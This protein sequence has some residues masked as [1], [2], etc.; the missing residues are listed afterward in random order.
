MPTFSRF[1][2]AIVRANG[3]HPLDGE[4][5]SS[6]GVD[7]LGRRLTTAGVHLLALFCHF[8]RHDEYIYEFTA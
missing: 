1:F 5:A 6:C 8:C 2:D 7:G 4:M 3:P